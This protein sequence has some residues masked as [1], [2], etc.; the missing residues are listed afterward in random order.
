MGEKKAGGGTCYSNDIWAPL[1]AAIEGTYDDY[2]GIE[3]IVEN[4]DTALLLRRILE[5]LKPINNEYEK[6]PD[7][8]DMTLDDA[9]ECIERDRGKY[10]TTAHIDS[11]LGVMFVHEEV[12]Q[13][14][15]NF[16]S[17]EAH[18]HDKWYEYKPYSQILKADLKSWY[19]NNL[20]TY[21]SSIASEKKFLRLL[22][23]TGDRF[24]GDY[25]EN[26][27]ASYKEELLNLLEQHVPFEDERVQKLCASA[28]ELTR[29]NAGMSAARKMWH[30]QSGKGGQN[31]DLDIYK[32][33]NAAMCKVI[34]EREKEYEADGGEPPD[35]NGYSSY[36]LTHNAEEKNKS[37]DDSE[38]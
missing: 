30:P 20:K 13:A 26:G 24:F 37:H 12:Y 4:D 17:I 27:M 9:L 31:N 29:F 38:Y 1:G 19:V 14:M 32:A 10:S 18:H 16:D 3:N 21:E 7:L 36:M 28:L 2:G 25:R 15:V 22:F 11:Y 35:E 34:D 8:K 6:S 23:S 33:I 5:G